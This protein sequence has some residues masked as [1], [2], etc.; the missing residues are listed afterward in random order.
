MNTDE[1][2]QVERRV[3]RYWYND[4]IAELGSGGMFFLLG[5]YFG[6]MGYFEEG[7]LVS[8][9]L[10]VSMVLVF[11]GGVVGVRWLVNIMKSRLTYPRTGYVEYHAKNSGNRKRRLLVVVS[12]MVISAVSIV[13]VDY[14]RGL[15]TIVLITGVLVGVIFIALRGRSSGLKRFYGLGALAIFLGI[16]LASSGLTQE[17]TLAIFYG[18]LG[19][20]ILVSGGLVLRSY[21]AENPSKSEN[22][23]E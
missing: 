14:V 15:Q 8:V 12:T 17:F 16:I 9:I 19:I 11:L 13:L 4:G 6:V 21:L 5:L 10:Q 7:S 2:K 18:F 20:A 3:M 22:G 1:M 23:N